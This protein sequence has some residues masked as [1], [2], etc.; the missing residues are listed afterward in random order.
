MFMN[1]MDKSPSKQTL[2]Q[3]KF[4]TDL[5]KDDKY[6]KINSSK[7]HKQFVNTPFIDRH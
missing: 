4:Y 6:D 5:R 7:S 1:K 3:I 2:H